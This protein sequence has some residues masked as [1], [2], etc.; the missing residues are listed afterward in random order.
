MD[1]NYPNRPNPYIIGSIIDDPHNFFGRE[2]LFHFIEDNLNNREKVILLHGQRRIGKSSVLAQIPHKVLHDQFFFVNYDL[3]SYI[4]KP[5]SRILHD[6]AQEISDH[7]GDHFGLDPDHLTPPSE[8]ELATDKAIF[9]NQFL[10]KLDRV[11]K[12]KNLVL[13]LDEFDV[14]TNHNPPSAKP[15]FFPYLAELIKQ[16]NKLFVIAVVGRNL[17]DLPTLLKLFGSPPYQEI[18]FLDQVSTKRLIT[19]SVQGV[20]IYESQAINAIYHLSAG[21]PYFTQ[22]LCFTLFSEARENQN[23]RIS[24]ADVELIVN[25]AIENA[26]GG[27][28]WLWDGLPIPE[29]VVFSAVAEAQQRAISP[30]Q[31]FPEHPLHPLS[32][33]K[34]YGVSQTKSLYQ[35]TKRL[36]H[37]GFLDDTECRVKVP[38]VQ[39]WLLQNH[40]LQQE[41]LALEKLD[42]DQTN[43]IYQLATRRYQQGQIQKALVL[44]DEVL[45]LNPNHF[46]ALLVLAQGYLQVKDFRQAVEIYRR[47]YQVKPVQ[48]KEGLLRSLLNY[49]DQLI[50]QQAFTKAKKPFQQ[51]LHIDPEDQLAQQKLEHIEAKIAAISKTPINPVHS[52]PNP[53]RLGIGKLAAGV[54]IISLVGVGFYNLSTPCPTG[55]QKVFGITCIAKSSHTNTSQSISRGEHSLFPKSDNNEKIDRAT[56]AFQNAN[57][58]EAAKFFKEA[59]QANR[60]NP[61]LLIYYNNARARQQGFKPFTIAVVVPI[62]QSKSTAQETLRGVAQAQDQ[63]NNSGGLNGQLL[64]IAIANDGNDT[65]KAE[66]IAQALVKDNSILGVIGHSSSDASNAALPVYDQ[67][68]LAIISS[69]SSSTYLTNVDKN[70]NVFFRIVPSNEALAKKL[71]QHVRNKPGLDKVVIFYDDDSVYSKDLKEKFETHFEQLGGKVVRE[72]KLNDANLNITQEVKNSFSQ[73]QVKAAMLFPRVESVNTAIN[74]AK[75]N[76]NLYQQGLRLLATSTLYENKTLISG[77]QAVEGLTI[78]VPWFREA[79][80]AITFSKAAQALWRGDVSWVTATSFDATQAFIQALFKDA[81]R[82]L[83]LDRLR[84]IHLFPSDTS[85]FPLQFTDQGER[86]SEPVLVQVVNGKFKFVSEQDQ[87]G[88]EKSP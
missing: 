46:S 82:K 64:E 41:I 58:S 86:Q 30:D 68:G 50:E 61:E 43:P 21:H 87:E 69:T 66:K 49:G 33:L 62:D 72:I 6:L 71:A 81:D 22:V 35:A 65:L 47:V 15:N 40:P 74:I 27:L 78:V 51:M 24:G 7:L 11:L 19:R 2:S 8:Q 55:E 9:S 48:S 59:W 42:Q 56:E 63:F 80:E 36:K 84:N 17:D 32:F 26:Q 54:A 34:R 29:R 60:N 76:A 88:I 10:P 23:W 85:G 67:A 14:L 4:H 37:N 44:Y 13:L 38:L 57:Y 25:Q 31:G 79:P 52:T 20:L 18:G 28:L 5:L 70:N 73:D 3:H 1:N 45:Q 75:A 39:R 12:G 83:V 77:Q 16:H 53:T